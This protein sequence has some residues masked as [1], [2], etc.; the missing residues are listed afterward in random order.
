MYFLKFFQLTKKNKLSIKQQQQ[1][2]SIHQIFL[3]KVAVLRKRMG[4]ANPF[5]SSYLQVIIFE[6]EL[7]RSY[8]LLHFTINL[9][10]Q[11]LTMMK[12]KEIIATELIS[13]IE[14]M[15]KLINQ[16]KVN[17][18]YLIQLNDDSFDLQNLQALFLENLCFSE[19]DINLVQINKYA[20]KQTKN[21]NLF[22]E[23]EM[24]SSIINNDKFDENTSVIFVSYKDSKKMLIN[25][26][27]SNFFNLFSF[28]N[29]ENII[30][31]SIE[32]IIPLAFQAVHKS[33]L[34][35][36]LQE[37]IT[38]DIF[39]NY[40][41]YQ[42][43]GINQIKGSQQQQI[44]INQQQDIQ[45]DNL[46][47]LSKKETKEKI[48]MYQSRGCKMNQQIIFASL[49]QMFVLPVRIDIRVNEFKEN[50]VFGLVAKVKQINKEYQY[51][52]FDETDLSVIGLTEQMHK[53]FFPSC[54][55]LQKIN[56]KQIFP[57]LIGTQ[58]SVNPQ[59]YIDPVNNNNNNNIKNQLHINLR[60]NMQDFLQDQTINQ[61]KNNNT[62]TFLVIQ[63][64]D[65][66][67]P[68]LNSSLMSSKKQQSM[69]KLNRLKSTKETSSYNFIYVE[70][71]LKRLNYKGVNNVSYIE[72]VKM[73]Q[74]H[75]IFQA[76]IILQ[77]ITNK[78]KQ[79]IYSQ[80]FSFPEELQNIIFDL[81][82][83]TINYNQIN[84]YDSQLNLTSRNQIN[85]Y[86]L[87]EKSNIDELNNNL[88]M[89]QQQLLCKSQTIGDE[90]TN[91]ELTKIKINKIENKNV[92]SQDLELCS[93]ILKQQ[94][95][96]QKQQFRDYSQN[97]YG[98]LN[99]NLNQKEQFQIQ[100]INLQNQKFITSLK[101]ISNLFNEEGE[102]HLNRTNFAFKDI[103]VDKVQEDQQNLNNNFTLLSPCRS[104][105]A[106]NTELVSPV[107]S[108]YIPSHSHFSNQEIKY[109][110]FKSYQTKETSLQDLDFIK[111]QSKQIF[112][113]TSNN[114]QKIEEKTSINKFINTNY[115]RTPSKLANNNV[116]SQKHQHQFNSQFDFEKQGKLH[117]KDKNYK[118]KQIQNIQNDIASTSSK[119]SSSASAKRLLEQ[120]VADK[121]V[122]QVIKVIKV[123]G[124]VCFAV[125]IFMTWFQFISM[126]KQLSNSNED[127][128]VFNW[129]TSYSSCLSD[130]VKYKNTLYLIQYSKQLSFS[131]QQQKQLFQ[132]R[133]QSELEFTLVEVY[134][135]LSQMSKENTDR[136]VFKYIRETQSFYS[137]GQMYN[138]TL[139]TSTPSDKI[140]VFS[141]PHYT[142]LLSSILLGIQL[143]FRYTHNLGNGRPEYYLLQNQL[144]AILELEKVQNNILVDQQNDQ[145]YIQDQLTIL[146]V[147]L[148][149]ISAA[150]VAVII[151]FYFYIQKEREAIIYLFTTFPIIKL[152]KLI[153]NIQNS[154]LFHLFNNGML[155]NYNQS[156]NIRLLGQNYHRPAN[157]KSYLLQNIAMHFN[158]LTMKVNPKLKPMQPDTY[159]DY[160]KT[161][162]KQQ[163]DILNDIQWIT[164][165]QYQ[166]QRFK[167]DEYDDFFFSAFKSNLCDSFKI[168]PQ[169]N[170]NSTRINV[171]ICNQSQQ[172]FLSQGLQIAY[173]S[174]LNQ[175]IDL[176][177]IYMIVDQSQQQSQISNFLS[178]FDIQD[179]L[180][181]IEFLDEAIISLNKFVLT[182]GNNYYLQIKIWLIVLIAFQMVLMV[183]IFSFGWIS[184]SNYLNGQLHKTKNYLTILDVN[185]LIENPYILTY[186]KKNTV[187]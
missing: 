19:K 149:I 18:N 62:I 174:L 118:K 143:T 34:K 56:L 109:N 73:R 29:K 105:K 77:E 167:Q 176:Y 64:S 103:S 85:Q 32:S 187:V 136:Q 6:N 23:D 148:V 98:K 128:K 107:Y 104:D 129:P 178:K 68:A 133:M 169:Y 106:L 74:L 130:I 134:D 142:S 93:Q 9:K 61:F 33:Y 152:D 162:I 66:I 22:K 92:S 36:Y 54:E 157:Y 158:I 160:L 90:S 135:L 2:N 121:S 119:D 180:A 112:N 59:S 69:K 171:G 46:E 4:R 170:T 89:Q 161:L 24:L 96:K 94:S 117:F 84:L 81:E 35:Q 100:N 75:P 154:L 155:P 95:I 145:Q 43:Q 80:L 164:K 186:I 17:L 175:F 3:K 141:Y 67:N 165:S 82:Q 113:L 139:L 57:F 26:V 11:I 173:K 25:Q 163:E 27:S 120:I 45:F 83:K 42:N 124:I 126:E 1:F 101:E 88:K 70:F 63:N 47:Q 10:L 12:Q 58:N 44:H 55:N 14:S 60:D 53:T 28:T 122:L 15:Q 115:N 5:D 108:N 168:Y 138:T 156:P 159:Y 110:E 111:S 114:L 181:F 116:L 79:D 123:I 182:Q 71:I 40:I 185:T 48:L 150:C 151:P 179:Y 99:S 13:K 65:M 7:E 131:S 37:E 52:L 137:L 147:V 41:E 21:Y 183:L 177:N 125:M 127:F 72:I 50:E 78:R 97:Q 172:G 153:K 39:S 87:Q 76:P 146:I 30:G 38:S 166:Y 184:F 16:L 51:V 140:G 49:S 8:S 144:Q 102:D 20:R 91:L 132:N 31:R 86:L